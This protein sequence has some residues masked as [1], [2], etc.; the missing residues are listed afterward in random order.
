MSSSI[1]RTNDP[2][3]WS[4]LDGIYIDERAPAPSV[5]GLPANIAGYAARFQRGPE[6][7]VEVGSTQQFEETFGRS[8]FSGNQNLKN[9][10]FGRLRIRRVVADD[11]AKASLELLDST[12]AAVIT[13]FAKDKGVYGNDLSVTV[14][15]GTEASTVKLTIKDTGTDAVL[16]DEVYDNVSLSGKDQDY[17]DTLLAG[18]RLVTGEIEDDVNTEPANISATKLTGG[19][20]GTTADADYESAL[21]DFETERAANFLFT[22]AASDAVN[23]YLEAHAAET[24]D[25]MVILAGGEEDSVSDAIT[26]VAD[27]RDA[28]GRIIY[29]YP[30]V[31]TRIDGVLKFQSPASW[32]AS[33]L[34]QTA[35]HI[36]PAATP[37]TQF[38]GG[39]TKLKRTITRSDYINLAADGIAAFALDPD[40]GFKVQS[41]VVTQ[42]ADSSKIMIYRRRMADFLTNSVGLFLKSYQ[43][44]VNNRENRVAVGAAIKQFVQQR[45]LEGIL[46]K[47]DEVEGGLAK[48]VDIESL[49][50]NDSIAQ[51]FFR[52]LWKQRIYS[53]M[54]FIVLTAEIGESVVVR[55]GE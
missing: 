4:E 54:R 41:G 34:S 45:E 52:I 18:S 11:A 16:P 5:R 15:A 38:L 14:E 49:N 17:V 23:G 40:I 43:N 55:E 27:Y 26:D 33:I 46:P 36:D 30:W 48:L 24:K 44:A 22:D 10:K 28:D 9:K 21:V 7:L 12:S 37:N 47:D 20:E 32:M 42:I 51:G 53:S 8:N 39:I 31:Q 2:T 1:S 3:Q 25:K 29:A 6:E 19:S 35:P 50:T 13:L